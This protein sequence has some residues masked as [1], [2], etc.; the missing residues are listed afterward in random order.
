MKHSGSQVLEARSLKND[1]ATFALWFDHTNL[2]PISGQDEIKLLCKEAAQYEFRSVC[3]APRWVLTAKDL[4]TSLGANSV[5]VCTV[6]GFPHGNTTTA[7]KAYESAQAADQGATEIDMVVSIGDLI[8][9]ENGTVAQ[10]IGDVVEASHSRHAIVK[11]ILETAYLNE[12]QIVT[13]CQLAVNAGADFV[14]T[15]T[16]FG[17][18]GADL[19][20]V[21]LMRGTVGDNV[22][23][24]AAGGIKTLS[25]ARAMLDA[26]ASRLGCSSS[27]QIMEELRSETAIDPNY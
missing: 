15:S 16:G 14:K 23:V 11:V 1:P 12:D 24:K 27:V 18:G 6:V 22:G 19:D 10:D 26:G 20:I 8:D 13:G 25:D 3:L 5:R 21:R 17:P 7:A 9:G 4:L 2:K